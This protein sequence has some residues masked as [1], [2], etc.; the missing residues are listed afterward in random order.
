MFRSPRASLAGLVLLFAALYAAFGVASPFLPAFLGAHGLPPEQIG[1]VLASGTAVRLVSGPAVS[2][3][4]DRLAAL[5]GVLAVCGVL[6]AIAALCFLPA[7]GF[8]LLFAVALCHAA[9]LA[10]IT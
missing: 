1:L 4:A 5:R 6:A 10:P 3:L 8:A 7:G 9:A 2:R